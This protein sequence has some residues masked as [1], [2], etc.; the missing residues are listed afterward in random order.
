MNENEQLRDIRRFVETQNALARLTEEQLRALDD[1]GRWA[2]KQI[3][4]GRTPTP[5]KLLEKMPLSMRLITDLGYM[6]EDDDQ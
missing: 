4:A 5:E 3:A 1:E 2:Q 6:A